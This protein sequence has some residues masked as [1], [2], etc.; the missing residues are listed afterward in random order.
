L[1]GLRWWNEVNPITGESVWV[2]ESASGAGSGSNASNQAFAPNNTDKRFFW[3]AMYI[4]PLL[5]IGLA[6]VAC[7]KLEFVWL[8][9]VV[10]ALVLTITNT[11]AFSRCDKF[12]QAS[13]TGDLSVLQPQGQHHHGGH[14]H[15]HASSGTSQQS[16]DKPASDPGSD[17]ESALDTAL[18][19]AGA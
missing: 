4:Q 13:Q 3:L 5:W 19:A 10:I 18:G 14:H 6:I 1:V 11:I 9:L 15:H 2:F 12:S 17:I 16:Y 7:F 8:S